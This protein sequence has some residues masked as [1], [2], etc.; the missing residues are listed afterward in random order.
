MHIK[1]DASNVYKSKSSHAQKNSITIKLKVFVMI[2]LLV[3]HNG[4]KRYY[5]PEVTK[6]PKM[7]FFFFLSSEW[8]GSKLHESHKEDYVIAKFVT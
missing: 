3:F 7:S 5:I 1:V 2:P 6:Q 4:T 8:A